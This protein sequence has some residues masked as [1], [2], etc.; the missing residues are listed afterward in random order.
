MRVPLPPHPL[1][2]LLFIDFVDDGH[3]DLCEVITHCSFDLLPLIIS[4]DKH[5]FMC[6]SIIELL[7]YFGN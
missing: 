2:H 1:W 5:L 4:D 3:S 6:V 7:L